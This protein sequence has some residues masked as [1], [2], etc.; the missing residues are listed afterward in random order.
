[1]NPYGKREYQ[2]IETKFSKEGKPL[3]THI[4]RQPKN[5]KKGNVQLNCIQHIVAPQ[6]PPV[7]VSPLD[8][9]LQQQH[10][11]LQLPSI[12]TPPLAQRPL[13]E[14]KKTLMSVASLLC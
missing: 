6:Q 7:M 10:Q 9:L 14:E 2:F 1:V 12:I 11:Q 3:Q 13:H 4:Y 8:T 5:D